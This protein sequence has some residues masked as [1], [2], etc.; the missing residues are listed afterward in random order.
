MPK[1]KV[2]SKKTKRVSPK[3]VFLEDFK[4][5]EKQVLKMSEKIDMLVSK[6]KEVQ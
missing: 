6:L 5:M 1:K 2:R 3:G 4:S